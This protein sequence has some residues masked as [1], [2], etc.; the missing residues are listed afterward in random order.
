MSDWSQ[1]PEKPRIEPEIIPPSRGRPQWEDF[2]QRST[3]RI[4][5]TRLGP[6]S[7]LGI[8]LLFAVIVAAVVALFLGVVLIA[9]PIVAVLILIALLM[10]L[11]R[12]RV[13][14]PR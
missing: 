8:V 11:L 2:G 1:P 4:Y 9:L 14:H 13:R 3:H 6:F 7:G 5:V 10:G 12:P